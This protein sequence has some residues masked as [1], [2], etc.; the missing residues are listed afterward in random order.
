MATK[1]AGINAKPTTEIKISESQ[2]SSTISIAGEIIQ[3]DSPPLLKKLAEAAIFLAQGQGPTPVTARKRAK[4]MRTWAKVLKSEVD[5]DLIT[6]QL[7]VRQKNSLILDVD[8]IEATCPL[9]LL[10]SDEV[11]QTEKIL[12]LRVVYTDP[13]TNSMVLGSGKMAKSDL[14]SLSVLLD[15]KAVLAESKT[16]K[17]KP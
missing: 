3:V 8:G 6:G 1:R 9:I 12:A 13:A 16:K 11:N 2:F 17:K 14:D 5:G 7:I 15:M 4:H 10:E